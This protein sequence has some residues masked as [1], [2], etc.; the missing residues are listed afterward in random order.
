M[1]VRY[2]ATSILIDSGIRCRR[3][4]NILSGRNTP[5]TSLSGILLTHEHYDHARSA[6]IVARRSGAPIIANSP[7]IEMMY[8]QDCEGFSVQ[9]LQTGDELSLGGLVIRSFPVAH[10][11]AECVGYVIR[12]GGASIV[13]AT[14]VGHVSAE[15]RR[16][17]AG[18]SLAVVEANHDLAWLQRGPYSAAM[19]AR[20]ASRTGHLSNDDCADALAEAL[21]AN[22]PF[23]IWLAHLSRVNNSVS[24]AR[25]SVSERIKQRTRVGFTLDVAVRD[26]PGVTWQSGGRSIQLA[27]L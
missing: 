17:L 27:L 9:V 24:L 18:A 14:D 25:R 8:G 11:A 10:D 23:S 2:G 19:K 21:E 16:E 13:Y 3:L 1:L 26:Q 7:T 15:L 12:A 20:I 5:I 4:S 22:G 6:P